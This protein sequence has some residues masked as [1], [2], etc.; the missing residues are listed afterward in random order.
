MVMDY[1]SDHKKDITHVVQLGDLMDQYAFSHF[2]KKYISSDKEIKS[3][4]FHAEKM[5]SII[6]S[7][8]PK[9]DLTQLTGN[10]DLRMFKR[11]QERLPEGQ[12]IIQQYVHELYKFDNVKTIYDYREP[13][14]IEDIRFLH[15]YKKHGTH[16]LHSMHKT[17]VGHLHT[18]G[19][20]YAN[21]ELPG[22]E[23]RLIWEAN[24]GYLGD[25]I[26]FVDQLGYTAERLTKWTVGFLSIDK[27]GPKFI[28]L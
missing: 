10:H 6:Y 5:W 20:V 16:M 9:A 15:G 7:L 8:V 27:F 4:R 1:I 3:A 22:G 17:V 21:V 18:A 14:W 25:E 19:I 12:E 11:T 23:K 26:K 24:A 2:A 13:L 28:S